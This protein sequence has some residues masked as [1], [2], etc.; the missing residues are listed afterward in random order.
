MNRQP[1]SSRTVRRL[2]VATSLAFVAVA[3]A[4]GLAVSALRTPAA[5]AGGGG[6]ACVP[7]SGPV[8]TFKSHAGTAFFQSAG[9][10]QTI[11]VQVF[12][13]ENFSRSGSGGVTDEPSLQIQ[14]YGT[15]SCDGASFYSSGALFGGD[16]QVQASNNGN[17]LTAQGSI[18]VTNTFSDGSTA[19][20]TYAV[21][22]TWQAAGKGSPS[23]QSFHYR[24]PYYQ[25]EG[26]FTGTSVPATVTGTISDGS[27][28]YV[29]TTNPYSPTELDVSSGTDV[30]I[31]RS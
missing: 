9:S 6:V 24:T 13:F 1:W 23:T 25:I 4:G 22:L 30:V 8:C 31:Y 28:T 2:V 12:A 21:D 18:P 5:H 26:H 17:V 20:V 15:N 27:N 29:Q 19:T 11:D 3:V 14:A 10:C 7:T 16:I